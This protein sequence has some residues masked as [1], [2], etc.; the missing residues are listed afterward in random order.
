MLR[1]ALLLTCVATGDPVVRSLHG[2][3][4]P[5]FGSGTRPVRRR[6]SPWIIAAWIASHLADDRS[7]RL[8]DRTVLLQAQ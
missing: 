6:P 1:L 7:P 2:D 5:R 3:A 8:P 4:D